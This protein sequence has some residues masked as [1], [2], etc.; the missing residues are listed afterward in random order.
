MPTDPHFL[1]S[2][3]PAQAYAGARDFLH[4]SADV[5][6]NTASS[7]VMP[8]PSW[9]PN[10]VAL[11]LAGL[12]PSIPLLGLVELDLLRPSPAHGNGRVCNHLRK[13]SRGLR[14]R[15]H[16]LKPNHK[17]ATKPTSK[18]FIL[19]SPLS[20]PPTRRRPCQ[21]LCVLARPAYG[22]HTVRMAVWRDPVNA[23]RVDFLR[24]RPDF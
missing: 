22:V 19:S 14:H 24:P 13:S 18:S 10:S 6:L 21:R 9:R 17:E 11:E 20:T 23:P 12:A 4:R 16:R 2:R 15:A 1:G 5:L 7:Q 3:T 8:G